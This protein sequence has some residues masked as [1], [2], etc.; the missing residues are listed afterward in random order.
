MWTD[1]IVEEVRKARDEHAKRLN[2]DLQAIVDDLKKQQKASNRKF[3]KLSP[4]RP[5]VLPKANV[6]K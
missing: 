2:N 5:V 1:P 4:R 6:N 3:V